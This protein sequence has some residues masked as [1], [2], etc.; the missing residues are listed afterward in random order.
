MVAA[1]HR[2]V[3]VASPRRRCA[4]P[5]PRLPWSCSSSASR[6]RRR[7]RACPHGAARARRAGPRAPRASAAPPRRACPAPSI[8]ARGR[9]SQPGDAHPERRLED[10]DP[11][12]G[13]CGSSA[14]MSISRRAR[15]GPR[16]VLRYV[17]APRVPWRRRGSR[18]FCSRLGGRVRSEPVVAPTKSSCDRE[19]RAIETPRAETAGR[20][21]TAVR[22]RRGAATRQLTSSWSLHRRPRL[23]AAPSPSTSAAAPRTPLHRHG[24]GSPPLESQDCDARAAPPPRGDRDVSGDSAEDARCAWRRATRSSARPFSRRT[25]GRSSPRPTTRPRTPWSARCTRSASGRRCAGAAIL[26]S[27]ARRRRLD[28]PRDARAVLHVHLVDCVERLLDAASPLPVR[29]DAR[30]RDPARP[31]HHVRA[32]AR[33]ALPRAQRLLRD[34]RAAAADRRAGG[35]RARAR[36]SRRRWR[37]S[38]KGTTSCRPSTTR[39]RRP[40]R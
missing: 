16:G 26:P 17:G 3:A 10:E 24:R 30:P 8:P 31:Q 27:P 4:P 6:R 32:V 35:R 2:D 22:R 38:P 25:S 33:A 37:G 39:R 12:S 29:D 13:I 40:T 28:L 36:S 34:R 23:R 21:A 1:V 5:P 14:S 20:V 18:E 15:R 7:E 19:N 9:R 11:R